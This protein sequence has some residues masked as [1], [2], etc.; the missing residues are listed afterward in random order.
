MIFGVGVGGEFPSSSSSAACR[1]RSAAPGSA[2]E[3]ACCASLWSGRPVAHDGRFY[4]FPE[5]A[6]DPP[7]ARP[8]GPPIWCGG[9]SDPALRRAGRLADGWMSYVIDPKRYRRSLETIAAA[10]A[11]SGRTLDR[12]G[13][14]HLLFVRLDK[15]RESALEFAAKVP[16]RP[17]RDG[18]Q[19]RGRALLRT[20]ERQRRC[21]NDPGV[22]RRWHAP[23]RGE[24]ALAGEREGGTSA[25]LRGRG[26][27]LARG[28][29][30]REA[31]P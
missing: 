13:T 1:W 5:V 4:P 14:S 3:F 19:Q 29:A 25:T 8:G 26:H 20:R 31:M 27:A 10:A 18:F 17:L 24:H 6:I 16:E 22:P 30:L 12:F 15:D 9:R 28:P 11:E 23:S 21:G 2:R 7:P